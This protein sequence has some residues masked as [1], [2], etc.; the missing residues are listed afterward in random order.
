MRT[1]VVRAFRLGEEARFDVLT[2]AVLLGVL[3]RR[4]VNPNLVIDVEVMLV[5]VV[6]S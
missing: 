2:H 6:F 1:G 3:R 5:F 4:V